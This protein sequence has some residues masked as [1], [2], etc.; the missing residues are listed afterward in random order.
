MTRWTP[1]ED[2]EVLK[3]STTAEL[4]AVCKKIGRTYAAAVQRRAI[5]RMARALTREALRK[6]GA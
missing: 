4:V 5:L 1:A 2:A 6:A 3:A